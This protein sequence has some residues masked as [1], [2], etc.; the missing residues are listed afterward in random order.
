[1]TGEA[2]TGEEVSYDATGKLA[3]VL[4]TGVT[5]AAYSSYQE[6]YVGGVYAGTD[7]TVTS[8]PSGASYSSYQLDYNG[9]NVFTGEDVFFSPR[10]GRTFH[11]GGTR[12][13]RVR[14]P[15][16]LRRQSRHR[17]DLFVL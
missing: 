7:Y 17:P 15:V 9:S 3:S 11:A 12:L 5:G 4:F 16:A 2:Y 13:R 8:V 6:N 1:M 14:Q 10:H